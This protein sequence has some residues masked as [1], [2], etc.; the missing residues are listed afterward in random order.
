ERAGLSASAGVGADA[1]SIE[2]DRKFALHRIEEE[3]ENEDPSGSRVMMGS[4]ASS[5]SKKGG[6][7]DLRRIPRS[8][9]QQLEMMNNR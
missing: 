4:I 5:D 8:I 1:S 6:Q 7:A 9:S 2:T 3:S